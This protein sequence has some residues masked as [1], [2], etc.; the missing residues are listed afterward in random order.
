MLV[1]HRQ[2]TAS[3]IAQVTLVDIRRREAAR[4]SPF[5]F[6][7]G[8]CRGAFQLLRVDAHKLVRTFCMVIKVHYMQLLHPGCGLQPVS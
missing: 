6:S 7:Y 4:R 1:R 8:S 3:I 5:H 2:S